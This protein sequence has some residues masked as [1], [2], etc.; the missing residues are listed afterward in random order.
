MR[1][2]LV[3]AVLVICCLVLTPFTVVTFSDTGRVYNPWYDVNDDG[4]ID[5][6]DVYKV[7]QAYGTSGAPL[8]KASIQYDSGWINI[9]DKC[10][11]SI[12]ITHNLNIAD[13]N[14]PNMTVDI[15][16][17]TTPD[18]GLLRFLGLTGQ[19][20]WNQAYGGIGYD[21]AY[22]VV[23]TGD[24][25]YAIAGTTASFGAGYGD[26]WLVKTDASG[27]IGG[28]GLV[29]MGCTSNSIILYRGEA[30]P[31]WNYV[32]VQIARRR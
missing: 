22:S 15:A 3:V 30:D 31:C 32:R 19:R 4:Q 26:G 5:V 12:T 13:W 21:Y 16:G 25:G 28:S 24:G 11:Q 6:K 2:Y 8:T 20:G 17:K 1:K 27:N 14:D 23:Q 18:G 9:T 29:W 7:C 10:G